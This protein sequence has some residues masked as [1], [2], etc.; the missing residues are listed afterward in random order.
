MTQTEIDKFTSGYNEGVLYGVQLATSEILRVLNAHTSWMLPADRTK[1]NAA[2]RMSAERVLQK[3][4]LIPTTYQ[5]LMG[6]AEKVELDFDM[7]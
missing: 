2:I 6:K 5:V 3:R 4:G 1:A 7:H